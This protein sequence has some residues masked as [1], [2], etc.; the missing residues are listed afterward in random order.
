MEYSLDTDSTKLLPW[1]NFDKTHIQVSTPPAVMEEVLTWDAG[2]DFLII[3]A[4]VDLI[5]CW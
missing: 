5:T 1:Q 3:G 4:T 2:G